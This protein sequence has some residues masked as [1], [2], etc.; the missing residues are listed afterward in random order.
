MG[1]LT[2]SGICP[3][4]YLHSLT[5]TFTQDLSF[6]L[7]SLISPGF[8]LNGSCS[9]TNSLPLPDKQQ[10]VMHWAGRGQLPVSSEN[11]NIFSCE[12]EW[13]CWRGESDL[14]LTAVIDL[15]NCLHLIHW[16][17]FFLLFYLLFCFLLTLLVIA[18]GPMVPNL[19]L[20]WFE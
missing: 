8:C 10:E 16:P 13:T 7:L 11:R 20:H 5:H 2:F 12:T 15:K 3:D 17:G 1:P 4:L 14:A 19:L 6:P 9:K 18:D